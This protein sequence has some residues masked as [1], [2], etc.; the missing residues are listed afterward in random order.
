MIIEVINE[1]NQNGILDKINEGEN[2]EMSFHNDNCSPKVIKNQSQHF[3]NNQE[4]SRMKKVKSNRIEN[5]S[6][7]P[8][9]IFEKMKRTSSKSL[10]HKQNKTLDL[11]SLTEMKMNYFETIYN[12]TNSNP[13]IIMENITQS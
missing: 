4:S 10:L 12:S 2:H 11:D 1:E 9:K 13:E 7:I 6:N 3:D 8:L 5:F